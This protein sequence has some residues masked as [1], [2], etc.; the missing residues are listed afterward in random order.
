MRGL[1]HRQNL[2][3]IPKAFFADP[4]NAAITAKLVE[5]DKTELAGDGNTLSALAKQM[6]VNTREMFADPER[7]VKLWAKAA[8][9]KYGITLE[10]AK[11]FVRV[12]CQ[13]GLNSSSPELRGNPLEDPEWQERI[14]FHRH[15]LTGVLE[16]VEAGAPGDPADL[17]EAEDPAAPPPLT[18]QPLHR[19]ILY[20][21]YFNRPQPCE[22]ELD[23]SKPSR[24]EG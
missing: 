12:V 17:E 5:L 20:A 19:R 10:V 1:A 11:L 15:V 21:I 14:A 9:S 3:P 6:A 23:S 8:R 18:K 7:Y 24:P 2:H 16:D 13:Y 4:D 22:E